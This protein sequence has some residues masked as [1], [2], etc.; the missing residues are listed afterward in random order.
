MDNASNNDIMVS[1]LQSTLIQRRIEFSG[2]T[3]HI[4]YVQYFIYLL[5]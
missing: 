2:S 5:I 1:E 3:Q 4:R